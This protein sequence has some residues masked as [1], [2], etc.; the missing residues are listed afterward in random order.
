MIHS[1]PAKNLWLNKKCHL[2]KAP[3]RP[4]VASHI[5]NK[6]FIT[7]AFFHIDRLW[8]HTEFIA[9]CNRLVMYQMHQWVLMS[10]D[11]LKTCSNSQQIQCSKATVISTG[12]I[13][14][15]FPQSKAFQNICTEKTKYCRPQKE[16]RV[17]K[18]YSS[19]NSKNRQLVPESNRQQKVGSTHSMR[20]KTTEFS[21]IIISKIRDL[22]SWHFNFSWSYNAWIQMSC[23]G[24]DEHHRSDLL[25]VSPPPVI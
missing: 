9:K 25:V 21:T 13:T 10:L 8:V 22:G 2:F 11:S 20:I 24:V 18:H 19:K 15:L 14:E 4:S 16:A 6:E 1:E 5:W 17:P 23:D 7:M 3:L 12:K